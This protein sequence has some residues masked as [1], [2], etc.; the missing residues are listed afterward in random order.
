MLTTLQ[1]YVYQQNTQEKR[2]EITWKKKNDEEIAKKVS[3]LMPITKHIHDKNKH[4]H[5]TKE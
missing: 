4:R 5:L 3:Y 2:E 1:I